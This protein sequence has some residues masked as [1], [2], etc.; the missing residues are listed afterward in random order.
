MQVDEDCQ[1][2]EFLI[3]PSQNSLTKAGESQQVP[4]RVMDVL[5]YLIVH[6][7]RIVPA[8]ELLDAF[9]PGRVVEES[10]IHRQINQIRKVLGDSA[11]NPKYIKT[12]SKRGYQ[13]VALVAPA[14]LVTPAALTVDPL[15]DTR[16]ELARADVAAPGEALARETDQQAAN[17][18]SGDHRRA[19]TDTV[20]STL[21][22]QFPVADGGAGTGCRWLDWVVVRA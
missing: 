8:D 20:A 9:W 22:K 3:E 2:G 21:A 5:M 1:F 11:Q 15:Q 16:A 6:R 18:A 10:T 12:V 14:T 19:G 4:P 7:D 13:A 17:P